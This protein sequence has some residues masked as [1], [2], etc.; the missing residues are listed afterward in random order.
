MAR[1]SRTLGAGYRV[2]EFKEKPDEAAARAYLEKGYLGNSRRG[3]A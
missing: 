3:E 2:A 1:S